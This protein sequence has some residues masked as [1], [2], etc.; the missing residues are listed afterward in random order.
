MCRYNGRWA[1][2]KKNWLEC[3]SPCFNWVLLDVGFRD[4]FPPVP[5]LGAHGDSVCVRLGPW[6]VGVASDGDVVS[7]ELLDSEV[8]E[9]EVEFEVLFEEFVRFGVELSVGR[10]VEVFT[11]FW[12]LFEGPSE[13]LMDDIVGL[14]AVRSYVYYD[15]YA[16]EE[17]VRGGWEIIPRT[18]EVFH[19]VVVDI[20]AQL[21]T[22]QI[23]AVL[24]TLVVKNSKQ[25][26]VC[27]PLTLKFHFEMV[28]EG[29]HPLHRMTYG[30]QMILSVPKVVRIPVQVNPQNAQTDREGNS[31][32]KE[33]NLIVYSQIAS[34]G[35]RGYLEVTF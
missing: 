33:F 7:F 23:R 4:V 11:Y 15:V 3:A 28:V 9:L 19:E 14:V 21:E 18:G 27:R 5:E 26:E 20:A 29:I 22:H 32:K 8:I 6:L 30:N 12:E 16:M 25:N 2:F 13:F 10:A 1:D 24:L 31:R 17:V 35:D 34:E